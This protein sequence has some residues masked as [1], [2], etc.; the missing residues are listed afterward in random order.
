MRFGLIKKIKVIALNEARE[1]DEIYD[2]IDVMDAYGKFKKLPCRYTAPS[3]QYKAKVV[4]IHK[5][6]QFNSQ[7]YVF[8][9][10]VLIPQYGSTYFLNTTPTFEVE[11]D[12]EEK[13]L[14][15]FLSGILGSK[16]KSVTKEADLPKLINKYFLAVIENCYDSGEKCVGKIS[17]IPKK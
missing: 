15:V 1:L 6:C 5:C 7:Y 14:S 12:S 13:H 9:L 10:Q 4:G 8:F 2:L 3:G 17:P 11:G 16:S